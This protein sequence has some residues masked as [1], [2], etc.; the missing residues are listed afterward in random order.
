MKSGGRLTAWGTK[1]VQYLNIFARALEIAVSVAVLIAVVVQI[2]SLPTLFY[3]FVFHN[4]SMRSFHTFLDNVLILAIGLEFFRMLCFT[5][6][7]T[8]LEV[9]LFVLARHMIVAEATALDNLL[10]VIG[11]AIVMALH[12]ALRYYKQKNIEEK[13]DDEFHT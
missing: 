11:I 6:T 2:T 5:N 3:V 13:L 10:T 1:L 9:V 4:D 8:V 7:D 12:L